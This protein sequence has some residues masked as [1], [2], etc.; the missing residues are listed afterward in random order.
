MTDDREGHP[1]VV[2][3]TLAVL[4]DIGTGFLSAWHRALTAVASFALRA[5]RVGRSGLSSWLAQWPRVVAYHRSA[6]APWVS[7][8]ARARETAAA[9]GARAFVF[10][11][12][13]AALVE[14][15]SRGIATTGLALA[16]VELLWAGAR[17]IIVA[18][19]MPPGAIDRKRLSVAYLA[20]LL[21]YLVGVVAPVRLA[22]LAGSAYLTRQ[23]L[24]GAGVGRV[25][26]DRAIAW[27]FGGQAAVIA[28]SWLARALLALVVS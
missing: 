2:T 24:L 26:A 12:L 1:G 11:I 15:S 20:G 5:G 9:V 18:V 27:S 28:T 13:A 23:G 16:L 4:G 8:G 25:D 21:P 14:A 3:D 22:A 10:G 17:F 7:E 19:L 6:A